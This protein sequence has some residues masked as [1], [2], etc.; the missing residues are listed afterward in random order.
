MRLVVP[1]FLVRS[2]AS[3]VYWAGE[4][5]LQNV[6]NDPLL[7]LGRDD[8]QLTGILLPICESHHLSVIGLGFQLLHAIWSL[9]SELKKFTARGANFDVVFFKGRC[10]I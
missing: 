1:S 4:A 8:G 5:L 3:P 7:A 6:L 2:D 10:R 9:E